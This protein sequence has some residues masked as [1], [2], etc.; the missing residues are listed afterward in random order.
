MRILSL[1]APLAG[2][3]T[4]EL[5]PRLTVLVGTTTSDRMAL[6]SVFRTLVGGE[7]GGLEARV[8]LNGIEVSLDGSFASVFGTLDA[9]DPV[10][11]RGGA[12]EPAPAGAP[13]LRTGGED[14]LDRL[15]VE[16]RFLGGE[17]E[18][19]TRE[20]AAEHAD[21][22][23]PPGPAAPA[24]DAL[25]GVR[26]DARTSGAAWEAALEALEEA[27]GPEE[28]FSDDEELFELAEQLDRLD[29][30]E[31]SGRER[32]AALE[33]LLAECRQAR[34]ALRKP[35]ASSSL[36]DPARLG[37]LEGVRDE[38]LAL[39][40]G[41]KLGRRQR[42]RLEDLRETEARL[43]AELGHPTYVSLL[44]AVAS[45]GG[46]AAAD[47]DP[48]I[49]ARESVLVELEQILVEKMAESVSGARRERLMVRAAEL[50]GESTRDL[51]RRDPRLLADRIRALRRPQADMTWAVRLA[52]QV[53]RGL[54]L[55]PS[56]PR[57][58]RQV[59]EA[60][61]SELRSDGAPRGG[62]GR[63]AGHLAELR[64]RERE[65]SARLTEVS[66][67]LDARERAAAVAA[68][69]VGAADVPVDLRDRREGPAAPGGGLFGAPHHAVDSSPAP[70]LAASVQAARSISVVGP[71]PLFLLEAANP[72]PVAGAAPLPE[73]LTVA[74]MSAVTQI[75]WVSDREEVAEAVEALGS[76]ASVIRV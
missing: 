6:Q 57:T 14:A 1:R 15:R 29:P 11:V 33:Q 71:M 5:H 43:L 49:R 69:G 46:V 18:V 42:Q 70:D 4:I 60:A 32:T 61:R 67:A 27:L 17:L 58:P 44:S 50:L 41:P 45:A 37:V 10:L 31:G 51:D 75:V 26:S 9:I 68:R 38:M 76:L 64:N 54:G 39:A 34:E 22:A 62:W 53:E 30:A 2:A 40:A 3:P 65:L 47:T 13:L 12:P 35:P 48:R 36:P 25:A 28:A 23:H 8:E 16:K 24:A 73:P 7:P 20:I 72:G 52:A 56:V 63:Q 74:A 59:L 55:D 19:V 21:R 66:E